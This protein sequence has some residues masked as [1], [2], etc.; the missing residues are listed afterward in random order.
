MTIDDISI[1]MMATQQFSTLRI[2]SLSTAK[3]V[4]ALFSKN[5]MPHLITQ[6]TMVAQCVRGHYVVCTLFIYLVLH[7]ITLPI[8]P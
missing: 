8:P 7:H 3:L 2:Q 4:P 5:P 6:L 1:S